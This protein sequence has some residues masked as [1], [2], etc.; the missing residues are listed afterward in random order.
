MAR[1]PKDRVVVFL[2]STT[3]GRLNM[4]AQARDDNLSGVIR[5]IITEWLVQH[6]GARPVRRQ[7]LDA[8]PAIPLDQNVGR[9]APSIGPLRPEDFEKES[10]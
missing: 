4:L 2:T 1:I 10:E 9:A 7:A 3:I 8:G 5:S 6:E